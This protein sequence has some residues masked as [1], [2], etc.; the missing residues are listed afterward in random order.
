MVSSLGFLLFAA[1]SLGRR[2]SLLISS[3]GQAATLYVIGIYSKLY[4]TEGISTSSQL[5]A[6]REAVPPGIIPP[7]G[8]VAIVCI[9][10]YVL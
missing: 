3:I 6:A 10:L 2:R 7:L 5:L 1:D 8:Y 9:Y 4:Q